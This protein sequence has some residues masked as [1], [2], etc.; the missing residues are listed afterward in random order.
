V[1]GR[2]AVALVTPV[3]P[4]ESGNGLAMRA[5]LTL[6]G[7]ARSHD[8]RVLVAPVFG[9]PGPPG[10]L[11]ERLAREVTVLPPP[12]RGRPADDMIARLATP[13]GRRLAQAVHPRPALSRGLSL[14]DARSVA[15]A[16]AGCAAVH[17]LRLYLAPLLDVLLERPERPRLV[18]DVDDLESAWRSRAG[19]REEAAAYARLEA[20]YLPAVD[21]VLACSA[22]DAAALRAAHGARTGV[23]PNAVRPPA[24]IAPPSGRHDLLFVGTLSYA[25]NEDGA[26]WLAGAV[27]PGLPGARAAVVGRAPGAGLRALAGPRLEVAGDVED[28]APWYAGARVAVVPLHAGGGTRIKA[29]EALAHGRPVVSTPLGVEGLAVG[30]AEGVLVAGDAAAFARA[31]GELL[32][33]P[34]RAARLGAAGREWVLE[35]ASVD[36][37]ARDLDRRLRAMLAP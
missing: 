17:V 23:L 32:A 27:L 13:A 19:A 8:V 26:R 10:P 2:R 3:M 9:P 7:L 21:A 24:A 29:I 11:V 12:G 20:A 5:G 35:H 4:A 15:R 37:V 25:P 33:D 1:S 22:Q 14:E 16:A 18:I 6:E 30:E 31:C 28:V 34:E 36:V